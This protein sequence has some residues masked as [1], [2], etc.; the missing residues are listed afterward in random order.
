[1]CGALRENV[2][3]LTLTKHLFF[4]T[5]TLNVQKHRIAPH[6]LPAFNSTRIIPSILC[7]GLEQQRLVHWMSIS[8]PD[9]PSWSR[10]C[11]GYVTLQS[12]I[13]SFLHPVRS[14]PGSQT[15]DEDTAN[16]LEMKIHFTKQNERQYEWTVPVRDKYTDPLLRHP[17][18]CVSNLK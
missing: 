8:E 13:L 4:I 3:E 15:C 9:N 11:A 18:V 7:T 12:H 6:W 14:Q 1:M 17:Y 2:F 16:L 10:Q 5:L